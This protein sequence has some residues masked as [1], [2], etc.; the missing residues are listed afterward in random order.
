M[1]WS[2]APISTLYDLLRP[3]LPAVTDIAAQNTE[4][5]SSYQKW[6]SA[7]DA[8]DRFAPTQGDMNKAQKILTSAGFTIVR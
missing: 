4:G 2:G 7:K 5:S 6:L 8:Q 3:T 1:T